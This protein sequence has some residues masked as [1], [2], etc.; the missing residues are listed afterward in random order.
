MVA[1]SNLYSKLLITSDRDSLWG[2]K[3]SSVGFR[4][5]TN[6]EVSYRNVQPS[7]YLSTHGIGRTFSEY[8]LLYICEGEGFFESSCQKKTEINAGNMFLLFPHE[9]YNYGPLTS[10]GWSGFWIGFEG[11]DMDNKVRNK[12]F[13]IDNPIFN[14]GIR[15]DIMKLYK[16]A[17]DIARLQQAGYQQLLGG[18]V[19]LLLGI[20]YSCR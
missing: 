2:L 6:G 18:I 19:D 4:K 3:V 16:D 13:T 17:I 5:I 1:N 14:I 20:A 11:R 9:W 10:S 8:Q 12:F 7:R 15:A